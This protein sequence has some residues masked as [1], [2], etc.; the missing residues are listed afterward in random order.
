MLLTEIFHVFQINFDDFF[1]TH[2]RIVLTL[3][4]MIIKLLK[5]KLVELKLFFIPYKQTINSYPF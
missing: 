4:I 5:K 2:D 3:F 1:I